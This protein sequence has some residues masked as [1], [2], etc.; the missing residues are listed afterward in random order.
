MHIQIQASLNL[1]LLVAC[2]S[3]RSRYRHRSYSVIDIDIYIYIDAIPAQLI[4]LLCGFLFPACAP[5][6]TSCPGRSDPIGGATQPTCIGGATQPIGDATQ[7]AG[8]S[9]RFFYEGRFYIGV[10]ATRPVFVPPPDFLVLP[11]QLWTQCACVRHCSVCVYDGMTHCVGC[12]DTTQLCACEPGCCGCADSDTESDTES[13]NEGMLNEERQNGC[14]AQ[15]TVDTVCP[16][17]LAIPTQ[18][19]RDSFDART[20]ANAATRARRVCVRLAAMA[21]QL[22]PVPASASLLVLSSLSTGGSR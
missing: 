3:G 8:S 10:A 20:Q 16:Q 12:W 22:P 1:Y 17:A 5:S 9:R 14:A 18:Q 15:P 4:K 2:C 13:I 21:N 6:M 11:P 19:P 7:P